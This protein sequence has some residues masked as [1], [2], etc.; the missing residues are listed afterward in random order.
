MFCAQRKVHVVSGEVFRVDEA[1]SARLADLGISVDSDWTA[2]VGG[3]LVY[4]PDNGF[5]GTDTLTITTSAS[6]P[7]ATS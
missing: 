6:A 7:L 4:T 3:E 5:N 1:W 2:V